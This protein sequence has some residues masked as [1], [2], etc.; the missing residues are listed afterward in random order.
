[1]MMSA[2]TIE[3]SVGKSPV[4]PSAVLPARELY[5]DMLSMM[6]KH[7]QALTAYEI[8]LHVS[9]NRKRSLQGAMH[10]ANALGDK[11]KASIYEQAQAVQ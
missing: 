2:A 6:G 11:D 10:A 1:M 7:E 5:G 8:A 9:P 4:T 3:D